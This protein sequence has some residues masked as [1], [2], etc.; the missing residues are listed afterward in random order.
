MDRQRGGGPWATVRAE[1][2]V[3]IAVHNITAL[4]RLLDV[5]PLV[6]GD[7]RVQVRF[8]ITGSSAFTD[9]TADFLSG[10]GAHPLGWDEA[11]RSRPDLV[12]TASH[13]GDLRRSGAP[14]LILPHGIGYNKYLAR[15]SGNPGIRES[16]NPGIRESGNPGIRESGNPVFGLSREWLVDADGQMIPSALVLSHVEQLNRLSAACPEA[17]PVAVVAG[18]PC[19]DRM[20]ASLPLRA[21]YRAGLRT[22][23]RTVVVVSS[24][25]GGQSLFGMDPGFVGRLAARLPVDRYQVVVALHPNAWAWHSRWQVEMWLRECVRA[26]V[27]VLDPVEGWRAAVVAADLVIGDHGSVSLY[28]AALGRP[29]ALA[30]APESAVDPASAIGRML[31]VA[32]RFTLDGQV[33]DRV[34]ELVAQPVSPRMAAVGE[35]ASSRRGESARLLRTTLYRLVDLPEPAEPADS[36]AVPVARPQGDQGRSHLVSARV[37]AVSDDAVD[38]EVVRYPAAALDGWGGGAAHLVVGLDEPYR[39]LLEL[40]EVVVVDG[41]EQEA[42][43]VLASLPGCLLAG[44]AS[45]RPVVL[46][47]GGSRVEF[48]V[49]RGE[50]PDA[51][52]LCASAVHRWLVDGRELAAL[53]RLLRLRVGRSPLD[54]EVRDLAR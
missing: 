35:L 28:S 45:T 9:G 3:V 27:V 49:V 34:D 54:V 21:V 22:R 7:T 29:V 20:V 26:G 4:T 24:T 25:W 37:V 47:T 18:D 39:R 31:A 15:E 19:L 44:V 13:G 41:A 53:P 10:I 14:V 46:S 8:A 11:A 36:A 32:P 2:L 12:V 16:G 33:A 48:E 38:M 51:A 50:H 6:A 43:E 42:V 30:V 23:G 40:A 5:L 52:A 17:V 1:K